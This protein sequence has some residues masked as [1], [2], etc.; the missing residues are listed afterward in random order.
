VLRDGFN[1][2]LKV[3]P[4]SKVTQAK[5]AVGRRVGDRIEITSGLDA[6]ARVVASGGGFL[7]DGDTVKVVDGAAAK[8][9]ATK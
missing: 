3:G 9:I 2:V 5:V 1:Y 6:A 4:D 8:P 7:S